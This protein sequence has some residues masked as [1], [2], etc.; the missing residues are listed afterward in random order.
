MSANLH[1]SPAGRAELCDLAVAVAAEAGEFLSCHPDRTVEADS[2]RD[3]KLRADF[4][5]DALI[6]KRLAE[7]S[8]YPILS[9]E[10]SA[11]Y[12]PANDS[13]PRWIVDPL[14]GS[15][16]Y[17]RGLPMCCV[18]IAFW[19]GNEPLVGVIYDFEHEECFRGIVPEGTALLGRDSMQPGTAEKKSAAVL[20]TGFPAKADFSAEGLTGFVSL[21]SD[22]KKLRWLGSA[23]LSVVYVACGRVDAYHESGI[24]LWDVAAG[25]AILRAAGGA[26]QFSRRPD[27]SGWIVHAAGNTALLRDMTAGAS[28]GD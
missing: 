14:D 10:Q 4:K 5:T 9:E 8:T 12:D 24:Q 6:H 17:S 16:N 20:C 11:A 13:G 25:L 1:E 2:A 19:N 15:L 21:I 3:V 22:Y 26:V 23:A 28:V 7:A 18:S 27:H